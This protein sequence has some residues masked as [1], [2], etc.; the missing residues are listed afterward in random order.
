MSIREELNNLEARWN[1]FTVEVDSL[2]LVRSL[3]MRLLNMKV[4]E[5]NNLLSEIESL[6]KKLKGEK[7]ADI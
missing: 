7:D 2:R 5:Q 6:R 3:L 4:R 1:E